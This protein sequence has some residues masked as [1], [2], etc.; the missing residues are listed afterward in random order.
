MPRKLLPGEIPDPLK[1]YREMSDEDQFF[2]LEQVQ[3]S[4]FKAFVYKE[5]DE[6]KFAMDEVL[7]RI[8]ERGRRR[9]NKG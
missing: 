1:D 9:K 2:A 7:R 3:D 8:E 5:I 6:N 4:E